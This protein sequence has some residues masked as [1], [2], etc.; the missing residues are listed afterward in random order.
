MDVI[1]QLA[2]LL[3]LCGIASIRNFMPTFIFC[4]ACRF[5]PQCGWCP[6]TLA[7]MS[8]QVPPLLLTD[9]ALALL[10]AMAL[11]E[12]FANWNETA[13]AFFEEANWET[14]TK[15]FY[16]FV[17]AL[18]VGAPETGTPALAATNTAAATAAATNAVAATAAATN[19]VAAAAA[20][21][22][23]V[24]AST[25][26]TATANIPAPAE[27]GSA[28][29]AWIWAT[30]TAGM[31]AL[32]TG[33]LC[34]FRRKLAAVIRELDPDNSFKLQSLAG[35]VEEATWLAVLVLV[36]VVPLLAVLLMG[37]VAACG[38]LLLRTLRRIERSRSHACAHCAGLV[39]DSAL[40]CPHCRTDQADPYHA[41]GM[42]GLAAPTLV[43]RNDATAVRTHHRGLLLAHRC[44]VC[45]S[46]LEDRMVCTHCGTAIWDQG[47][48]REE[49]VHTLDMRMCFGV[50]GGVLASALPIVGFILTVLCLNVGVLRVVRAYET[51]R[52]RMVSRF[53]FSLFKWSALIVGVVLSSIPFAGSLFLVPYVC[54]YLR[55]RSRLLR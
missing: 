19:V 2:G 3:A 47:F 6:T 21:T 33:V 42:F 10:G 15:P 1:T 43:D 25:V 20:A 5:G 34:A 41:V 8:S 22:N 37:A 35:G 24:V 36:V 16:A 9:G 50:A 46:A 49:F 31:G 40:K 51:R 44:P 23:A 7:Q 12:L 26:E 17:F 53:L 11:L 55:S 13:R 38:W 18:V 14:Y 28:L 52:G 32:G 48:S 27:A 45:A 30:V 29:A 4:M 54:S 39:H